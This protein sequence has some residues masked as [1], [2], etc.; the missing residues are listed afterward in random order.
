MSVQFKMVAVPRG[1]SLGYWEGAFFPYEQ[2]AEWDLEASEF[3]QAHRGA[4]PTLYEWERRMAETPYAKVAARYVARVLSRET[5][6]ATRAPG[7]LMRRLPVPEAEPAPD[8]EDP[9]LIAELR[10]DWRIAVNLD[11][12]SKESSI[13]RHWHGV[14]AELYEGQPLDEREQGFPGSP[15]DRERARREHVNRHKKITRDAVRRGVTESEY[16]ELQKMDGWGVLEGATHDGEDT[17]DGLLHV[18]VQVVK[19]VFPA[20]PLVT[21]KAVG[22]PHAHTDYGQ[23]APSIYEWFHVAGKQ[24]LR[25]RPPRNFAETFDGWW[26]TYPLP[27]G[28]RR[29]QLHE[30]EERVRN[31][32]KRPA[33]RLSWHPHRREERWSRDRVFF[34]MEGCLKEAALASAGE[35]TLSCPSVT[36]WDAYELEA[37]AEAHLTGKKVFVVCDSDWEPGVSE[38]REDDDGVLKQVLLLRDRL[39]LWLGDENVHAA[40][41]PPPRTEDGRQLCK[42]STH[43]KHGVD[44]Y[45]GPCTKGDVMDLV[46]I[47]RAVP[48][49][50]FL[51]AFRAAM[52]GPLPHGRMRRPRESVELKDMAVL[53]Y[54][55]QMAAANGDTRVSLRSVGKNLRVALDEPTEEASISFVKRS[56]R[57]LIDFGLVEEVEEIKN[58]QRGRRYRARFEDWTGVLRVKEPFRAE[59]LLRRVRDYT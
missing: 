8:G 19:Y 12:R 14:E 47:E 37:F 21:A 20:T 16:G 48:G 25:E 13:I 53:R 52:R 7:V 40:A 17:P 6:L 49:G 29:D 4:N 36:L 32:L 46:V 18:H 24:H 38:R 3:A 44:D 11:P 10:P 45:L 57:R 15:A 2:V 41:P 34:A 56:V 27:D 55:A 42:D 35:A 31:P 23:G 26:G 54:L 50:Q 43:N 5:K 28:L 22:T 59:R 39:R 1:V 51:D 9:F 33:K 30:H 58:R